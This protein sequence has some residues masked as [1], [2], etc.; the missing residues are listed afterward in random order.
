[1]A[2]QSLARASISMIFFCCVSF[3]AQD[4]FRKIGALLQVVDD[5]PID[6]RSER[7]QCVCY[8]IMGEGALLLRALHEHRDR[9]PNALVDE[10][11]ENLVLVAKENRATV[12]HRG[13]GSDLH[14]NNGFTH[15]PNLLTRL[16][17]KIRIAFAR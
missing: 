16:P 8:Q 11:H 12:A 4:K 3:S 2:I 17:L 6:L 10:H 14:F 9:R 5:Y 13:N 15:I 7:S 1:M